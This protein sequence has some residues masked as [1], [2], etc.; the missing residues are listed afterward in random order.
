MIPWLISKQICVEVLKRW[1][2]T[3]YSTVCGHSFLILQ[4]ITHSKLTGCMIKRC[5][6]LLSICL[7][8]MS[9]FDLRMKC[10]DWKAILCVLKKN[11]DFLRL[12]NSQHWLSASVSY[13]SAVKPIPLLISRTLWIVKV[14][15]VNCRANFTHLT[16]CSWQCAH[17][18]WLYSKL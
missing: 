2:Y 12:S 15:S 5:D 4:F 6:E 9:S 8:Q 11:F 14:E 13:I 17:R 1:N 16:M 7:G 18:S 10:C 3:S